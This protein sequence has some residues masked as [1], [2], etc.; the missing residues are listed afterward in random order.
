MP[1][2]S[3][4]IPVTLLVTILSARS[5]SADPVDV[6]PLGDHGT[7]EQRE[8]AALLLGQWLDAYEAEPADR[9]AD[10]PARSLSWLLAWWW[11]AE[12][13]DVDPG[14]LASVRPTAVFF[15][16]EAQSYLWGVTEA[17]VSWRRRP[18]RAE[19][20]ALVDTVLADL[21]RPGGNLRGQA[22]TRLS[23]LLVGPLV[24][25]WPGGRELQ[26]LAD[27]VVWPAPLAALPDPRFPGRQRPLNWYGPVRWLQS[28]SAAF[29]PG[30]HPRHVSRLLAVGSLGA[31][32]DLAHQLTDGWPGDSATLRTGEK[33]GWSTLTEL[34]LRAYGTMLLADRVRCDGTAL[35]MGRGVG[36]DELVPLSAL[37]DHRMSRS[38]VMLPS[39][40][41]Q[42]G[43]ALCTA[44]GEARAQSVVLGAADSDETAG[45]FARSFF[46]YWNDGS[47]AADAL[48]MAMLEMEA[49]GPSS[50]AAGWARYR[51]VITRR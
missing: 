13:D 37:A 40:G 45:T 1:R 34:D 7:A 35:I 29:H 12:P 6:S 50:A 30:H 3:A 23:E 15:A 16:G 27:D 17:G 5:G 20:H 48:R 14:D 51:V 22:A 8:D 18:G 10:A 49:L 43:Q 32:A 33:A 25:R 47:A 19:L 21:G 44:L 46:R 4:L 41:L 9:L 36:P 11:G 28:W 39:C 31:A 2:R 24:D 42:H 38:L 26:M